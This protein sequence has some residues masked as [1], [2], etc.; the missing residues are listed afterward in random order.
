MAKDWIPSVND[1]VALVSD[2][3][4]RGKIVHTTVQYNVDD[5]CFIT[6]K[7]KTCSEQYLYTKEMLILEKDLE[8]KKGLLEKIVEVI[9]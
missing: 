2:T 3:K 6:V 1:A 8:E 9:F 5:I 4:Y 7:W